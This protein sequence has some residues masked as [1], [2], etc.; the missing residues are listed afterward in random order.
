VM[1]GVILLSLLILVFRRVR[2]SFVMKG[3]LALASP[4]MLIFGAVFCASLPLDELQAVRVMR[5]IVVRVSLSIVCM[6]WS[7]WNHCLRYYIEVTGFV[8]GRSKSREAP[9]EKKIHCLV[10]GKPPP[11]GKPPP[12]WRL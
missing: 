6:V 10:Y 12:F 11:P 1:A 5:V 9:W 4:F 7:P 3:W 8:F 2:V